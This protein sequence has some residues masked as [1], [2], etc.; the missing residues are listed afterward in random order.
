[1]ST[2]VVWSWWNDSPHTATAFTPAD[3][4]VIESDYLLHVFW[5]DDPEQKTEMGWCKLPGDRI[6][7]FARMRQIRPDAPGNFDTIRRD[8]N[9]A[10]PNSVV[11]EGRHQTAELQIRTEGPAAPLI[12]PQ[13]LVAACL[14]GS[15]HDVRML[16]LQFTE[17][18]NAVV[19]EKSQATGASSTTKACLA[20][21]F[22]LS[23]LSRS[24][25]CLC[26]ETHAM[27]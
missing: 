11:S 1:M 21:A 17:F 9:V 2:S 27:R 22:A 20:L 23:P 5:G 7:D 4:A 3:A 24:P 6:I 19:D 10:N 25:A 18:A 16:L 13:P 8:A 15:A 12:S 14:S 26:S